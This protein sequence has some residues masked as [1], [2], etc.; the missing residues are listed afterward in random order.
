MTTGLKRRP[1]VARLLA[2]RENLLLVTGLGSPT[3]DAAAAGDNDLNYYLWGAMGGAGMMGLGLA[4]A[5]PDRPVLVLTGDGEMLMGIGGLATIGV[6]RPRNLTI[7][8]LDNQRYGETGMQP[9]HTASGVSLTAIAAGCGFRRT[10]DV[11]DEPGLDALRAQAHG[12][13]G[14]VF[15]NIRITAEDDPR[16]LPTFDGVEMKNRF[17]KALGAGK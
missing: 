17:R 9:S 6:Q 15:A 11:A 10:L 2:A 1:A 13:D 5:C 7:A 12:M 14:P 3:Y 8:V 16:V 4:L